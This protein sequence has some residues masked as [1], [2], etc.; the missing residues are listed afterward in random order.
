MA[1]LIKIYSEDSVTKCSG[2]NNLIIYRRSD[3]VNKSMA[4]YTQEFIHCSE[5][6]ED[7]PLFKWRIL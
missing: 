1:Q 6:N 2:C 3:V 7:K 5:C 4:G